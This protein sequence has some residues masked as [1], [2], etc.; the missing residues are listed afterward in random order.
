MYNHSNNSNQ[1]SRIETTCSLLLTEL[2]KIWS[3]VGEA[4]TER[5]KLVYEIEQECVEVY[6]RKVIAANKRR[7]ELQQ[8]IA[9]AES[10][11][12]N[13]RSVLGEEPV[14]VTENSEQPS[15][16]FLYFFKKNYFNFCLFLISERGG[17][18]EGEFERGAWSYCAASRG[19]EE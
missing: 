5:D 15:F 6:R 19:N 2:K 14:K 11:I 18:S 17:E 1:F 10:E 9:L 4:D 13:I 3:E 16:I 7:S 8:S 12:E